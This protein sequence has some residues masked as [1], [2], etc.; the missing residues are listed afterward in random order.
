MNKL[1]GSARL[2][3]VRSEGPLAPYFA[4]FDQLLEEQGYS[5]RYRAQ[6]TH[7]V[8]SF[9]HW[10][11]EERIV[12]HALTDGHAERFLSYA[13]PLTCWRSDYACTLRRLFQLLRQQ[14]VI[15]DVDVSVSMT[16]AQGAI[17]AYTT[18]LRRQRNLA[19]STVV[20]YLPFV[21]GFLAERFGDGSIEFTSL[22]ATDVIE[23]IRR[24]A[25]HIIPK[26]AKTATTALRSFLGY[27]QYRG[28]IHT[29]LAAAVPTVS[30]WSMTGIPRAI[31]ADDALAAITHCRRETSV[32]GRDY[33]ILLLL[34]RLGLR[35]GE[36]VSLTLDSVDW[37]TGTL[38]VT[39]KRGQSEPMPLPQDVGEA[40]ANYLQHGRPESRHRELF[41]RA[42]APNRGF[43]GPSAVSCVVM[44]ALARAG[45][46]CPRK[47]A[48]QFRH[49][50]ACQML[51][52]GATLAEIGVVLRHR[53]PQTTAIY[54]KCDLVALRA[55][56]L[57]WPGDPL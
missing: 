17:D 46:D 29:D 47:G 52:Q 3:A 15:A 6:Q 55:L 4:M 19:E 22:C 38:T 48:H 44:H 43:N 45:V 42:K 39:G 26:R 35:A 1:K 23:Y 7:I 51:R 10:L 56:S 34:S 24:L 37:S 13:A 32:G 41:L 53:D 5:P 25:T 2:S 57:P 40:I 36:I 27:L 8:A 21:R 9:N 28:E 50:L 11:R 54:A 49:A 18:Y 16:P 30:L 14:S 20:G 33:A 12:I 31:A